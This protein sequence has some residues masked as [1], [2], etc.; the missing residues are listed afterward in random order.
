[1][2]KVMHLVYSSALEN[3]KE[4]NSSFDTAVLR[5]AYTGANKNGSFISKETFE[6]CVKSMYNCPV[7]CNY[8][9]DD[10]SIGGHDVEIVSTDDGGLRFVN[11]TEPIGVIPESADA[12]FETV[13]EGDGTTHEYL[14]TP[15][16]LWKRQEAYRKIKNDGIESQSMEI[17]VK[18][19]AFDR[20]AGVY[21]IKDF[22]FTAF[23]L[24]GDNVAPCFESAALEV[25]SLDKFKSQM[26]EMMN[27]FK[28]TFAM[29]NSQDDEIDVIDKCSA[30]GGSDKLEEKLAL[31]KEF[32]LKV[33]DLDFSLDDISVED[34]RSKLEALKFDGEEG[35]TENPEDQGEQGNSGGGGLLGAVGNGDDPAT[36]GGSDN[37]GSGSEQNGTQ[38]ENT[39]QGGNESQGSGQNGGNQQS[40]SGNGGNQQSS[41]GGGN[42]PEQEES[43]EE[44][45]DE[46]SEG[47]P[48]RK[49][50]NAFALNSQLGEAIRREFDNGEKI[51]TMWG[52]EPRYWMYDFDIDKSEAYAYDETNWNIYGFSYSMNGDNVVINW[53]S[54]KRMKIS[55]DEFDEGV[56]SDNT[57]VFSRFAEKC[58]N[59]I[60]E[61]NKFKLSIEQKAEA[62]ARE[63]VLAQ[64]SDLNDVEA[65]ETLKENAE[66]YSADV[67]E[68]KC[69]AIRGRLGFTA[70][71][72]YE[73]KGAKIVVD[74]DSVDDVAAPYG[75]V[76]EEYNKKNL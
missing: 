1:M 23:C 18:D 72:S 43:G 19:G 73:N 39:T 61:L 30:K 63:N 31:I 54:R 44:E 40:D 3:F 5:I 34:L 14:C 9:R 46:D 26:A 42:E 66:Q 52:E 25:F 15:V 65:F 22:E 50:T 58:K 24:L 10:D 55:L 71:F 11:V 41:P 32:G 33:E 4:L 29:V 75:G 7:V 59:K 67:L 51:E 36:V 53:N 27:E 76:V 13:E 48:S 69:F 6:R 68:E 8:N 21:V 49:N 38:N 56:A 16:I 57:N 35:T 28:E 74:H 12:F 45:S 70:K 60:D 37:N 20:K 64:F 2:G 17:S 47:M 62:E